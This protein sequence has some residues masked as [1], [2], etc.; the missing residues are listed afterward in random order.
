MHKSRFV[1][2]CWVW[3]YVPLSS[4]TFQTAKN[5]SIFIS[6]SKFSNDLYNSWFDKVCLL[7]KLKYTENLF[8]LFVR[9]RFISSFLQINIFKICSF[10]IYIEITN[11]QVK[12]TENKCCQH[13]LFLI[14]KWMHFR[15][16][17]FESYNNLSWY[18]NRK[19]FW[20]DNSNKWSMRPKLLTYLGTW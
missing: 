19:H 13:D 18:E 11:K 4:F 8:F 5:E 1:W 14:E 20:E 10:A 12:Y 3:L 16:R 15:K 9:N 7:L 17:S 6:K 2:Y